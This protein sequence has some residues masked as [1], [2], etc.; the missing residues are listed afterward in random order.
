MDAT[1][2][3]NSLSWLEPENFGQLIF[4][5]L[6]EVSVWQLGV[7]PGLGHTHIFVGLSSSG[8]LSQGCLLLLTL[9]SPHVTA[10]GF[11]IV[12]PG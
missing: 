8:C 11:V 7:K 12:N 2:I 3:S 9:Q 1:N 4:F 5:P 6:P 10:P